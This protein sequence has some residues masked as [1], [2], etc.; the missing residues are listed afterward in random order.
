MV[1]VVM[2]IYII[3][4]VDSETLQQIK[5]RIAEAPPNEK[6]EFLVYTRNGLRY[7]EKLRDIILSNISKGIVVYERNLNNIPEELKKP[8]TNENIIIIGDSVFLK[9]AT[10]RPNNTRRE[11]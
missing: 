7:M 6:V 2:R 3:G 5:R 11:R 1:Y 4:D 8:S 10:T 9:E